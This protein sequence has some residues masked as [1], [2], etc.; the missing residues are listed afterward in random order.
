MPKKIIKV[1]DKK[2]K[3]SNLDL[4][5]I[6]KVIDDNPRAVKKITEGIGELIT[7]SSSKNSSNKK[8]TNK[9]SSKSNLVKTITDLLD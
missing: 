8:K 4:S 1:E 5:K 6:K 3:K 7:S 2:K 9:K